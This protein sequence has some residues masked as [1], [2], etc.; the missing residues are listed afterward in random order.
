MNIFYDLL[1]LFTAIAVTYVATRAWRYATFRNS[2]ADTRLPQE[3]EALKTAMRAVEESGDISHKLSR[4]EFA[5]EKA[6]G[7][8]KTWP[9]NE[10]VG[11]QITQ[12]EDMRIALSN[13]AL[14]IRINDLV[15]RFRAETLDDACARDGEAILGLL[16]EEAKKQMA[17]PQLIAHYQTTMRRY[18]K[19]LEEGKARG[20][21][22]ETS[23]THHGLPDFSPDNDL[24]EGVRFY[25][26]VRAVEKSVC[27]RPVFDITFEISGEQVDPQNL[28]H[29]LGQSVLQTIKTSITRRV[30]STR[31]PEHGTAAEIVVSGNSL[32]NLSWEAPRCCPKLLAAVKE[33]L[34]P[35]I[36]SDLTCT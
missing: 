35:P 20:D 28:D 36:A 9:A 34:T 17:D 2:V 7:I 26:C 14:R 22:D 5:L 19:A 27:G 4:V 1:T 24:P 18:L 32:G 30:H 29:A 13:D 21:I 23:A 16:E 3:T 25:E 8:H 10:A 11:Q 33:K 12:L 15:K 6:R 31:C